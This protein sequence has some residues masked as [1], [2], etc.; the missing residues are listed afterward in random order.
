[1]QRE[2]LRAC[3]DAGQI[4]PRRNMVSAGAR[5]ANRS[6]GNCNSQ[7]ASLRASDL[8]SLSGWLLIVVTLLPSAVS[9]PRSPAG[10][11]SLL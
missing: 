10:Q 4:I 7:P 1:M 9:V 8:I 6:R 3:V 2:R 5:E 11:S